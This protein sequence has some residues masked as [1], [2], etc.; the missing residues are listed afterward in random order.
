MKISKFCFNSFLV[1][2]SGVFSEKDAE[3]G[4]IYARPV[5]SSSGSGKFE[6]Y[7]P[8]FDLNFFY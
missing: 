4:S 5:S 1:V 8:T 3:E 6:T 7:F 2:A